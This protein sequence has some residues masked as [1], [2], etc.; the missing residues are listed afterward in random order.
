MTTHMRQKPMAIDMHRE[1]LRLLDVDEPQPRA[2]G[3]RWR[4]F[5]GYSW[6]FRSPKGV[7]LATLQP[8]VEKDLQTFTVHSYML[9]EL[10]NGR[11]SKKLTATTLTEAMHNAEFQARIAHATKLRDELADKE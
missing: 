6:E 4:W 7:L 8:L 1:M 3:C 10:H 5:E 9:L 11:P 2:D